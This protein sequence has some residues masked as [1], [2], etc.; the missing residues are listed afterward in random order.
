M[1]VLVI[2]SGSSSIKFQLLQMKDESLQLSGLL[3]RIPVCRRICADLDNLGIRLDASANVGVE[4]VLSAIHPQAE[5]S[6]G[7]IPV[8]VVRT[9]EELEIARQTRLVCAASQH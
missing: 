8:L 2:N 1:L 9:N 4:G 7:R 3:E 6:P 5:E